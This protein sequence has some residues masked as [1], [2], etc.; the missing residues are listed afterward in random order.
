MPGAD[1]GPADHHI[2]GTLA[3]C[4][5]L[6]KMSK[7]RPSTPHSILLR[8]LTTAS[9]YILLLTIAI[10]A[11]SDPD[12]TAN[13]E[14]VPELDA[15]N[16]KAD[17]IWQDK[18][19]WSES[20]GDSK[21]L[22]N[23]NHVERT[24]RLA[25]DAGGIVHYIEHPDRNDRTVLV[26]PQEFVDGETPLILSLHGYGGN[27]ANH[28]QY[29]PLHEHVNSHGFALLLPTGSLDAQGNPFW[30]PTD[31]CCDG[32]K[33]GQNDIAYLTEL[34]AQAQTL[35]DF[36]HIY[37]FGYS[38]GGFMAH[39]MACKGLP[40]LRA[41]ASLAGTSYVEDSACQG[42]PPVSILHIHGTQ[43]DIIRFDG[44]QTEPDPKTD[45][46]SP[47]YASAHN[48]ITRWTNLAQCPSPL[49][50]EP[51]ATLDL[52][53]HVPGPETQAFTT[54]SHCPNNI[55]IEL[56]ISQDSN[57]SPTYNQTFTNTLLNW[58]LTQN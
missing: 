55:N 36:G 46:K 2:A 42:A 10:L 57:H 52:D 26:T 45:T 17:A 1:A 40:G 27:A 23:A 47:F 18:E 9:L 44:E 50:P 7:T 38:N 31:H 51:Y 41:I 6:E 24:A 33:S 30:N 34:V 21:T 13:D 49:N 14:P 58:L 37:I 22:P 43:D 29:F 35:K 28:S 15:A 12:S 8:H 53:Q 32:G 48:M 4:S 16:D 5:T 54:A 11:C 3:P 20:K 19:L 39:H 25:Q 56:W